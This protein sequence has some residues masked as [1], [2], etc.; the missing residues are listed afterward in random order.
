MVERQPNGPWWSDADASAIPVSRESHQFTDSELNFCCNPAQ[1]ISGL[2]LQ[3]YART[4]PIG[5]YLLECGESP[6]S[7]KKVRKYN[8]FVTL[9]RL[10]RY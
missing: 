7:A 6:V 8:H 5:D 10:R 3:L 1:L 4:G 9:L 2:V